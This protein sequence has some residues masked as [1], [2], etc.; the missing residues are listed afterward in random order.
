MTLTPVNVFLSNTV[1]REWKMSDT[2]PVC[3]CH[4]LFLLFAVV[5][6][7]PVFSDSFMASLYVVYHQMLLAARAEHIIRSHD[8]EKPLFLY[9]PFQSVHAPLEVN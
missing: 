3:L 1:R 7:F 4:Y 9:L 8:Q 2:V 5:A 6:E